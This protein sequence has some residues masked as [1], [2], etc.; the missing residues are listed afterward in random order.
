VNYYKPLVGDAD[1]IKA[2]ILETELPT[3]SLYSPK[4]PHGL[5]RDRDRTSALRQQQLS[6]W[7][8]HPHKHENVL[9]DHNT[10]LKFLPS[11]II[12]IHPVIE[13]LITVNWGEKT[14]TTNESKN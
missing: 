6:Q 1:S 12:P 9:M 5:A 2:N 7:N 14:T 11:F 8:C 13:H 3:V 10:T 4:S